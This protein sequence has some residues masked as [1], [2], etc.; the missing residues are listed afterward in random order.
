MT[1]EVALAAALPF[2][3]DKMLEHT[4]G[5]AGKDACTAV[6]RLI[7]RDFTATPGPPRNHEVARAVRRAELDALEDVVGAYHQAHTAQWER[8]AATAP[9]A[10]TKAANEFCRRHRR[11]LERGNADFVPSATLTATIEALLADAP[12]FTPAGERAAALAAFAEEA[13]LQELHDALPAAIA[14]PDDFAA[15]LRA[16]APRFLDQFGSYIGAALKDPEHGEFRAIL[17]T[18]WLAELKAQGFD[19]G[20]AVARLEQRLDQLPETIVT[21]LVAELEK[22]D[23]TRRA[24]QAGLERRTII[25]LARRLKPQEALDFDQALTELEHA[26]DIAC[27][28]IARGERPSNEDAFVRGVLARVADAMRLGDFDRGA[29]EVD[30]A[31]AELVRREADQRDEMRRWRTALLEA[32][33]EQDTLRR[34]AA[35]VAC[36]IEA[37]VA[38]DHPTD[39]AAW[40]PAFQE[41]WDALLEEGRDKGVNFSLQV[42]AA[43]ARRM[44][45]TARDSDERGTAGN[46][47]GIALWTLGQRESGTARLDQAVAAY[48]AALEEFARDRAAL[49]WARTQNNLG[50]AL[51][52]LGERE[53]GTTRLELAVAAYRAALEEFARDRAALDW[54]RTQNNLGN[55]LRTLGER[56]SGTARLELAVAAYRAALEERTRDRVPLDWA[57]TQMNLGNAL[58]TLGERESGTARLEQAVAAYRAALEEFTRD[59]VPL[60]WATTQ[61]NLG[62]ALKALGERESG[63]ARL[64]QAVAAYHATLEERTCDRVPLDWATT[65]MNLGNALATLG[66]R[67]SGTARLEQ[68]VAAWDACLAVTATVWPAEWVQYVRDCRDQARSEIKQRS[69]R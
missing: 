60:D 40:T 39:R 59:R 41:R 49:D 15:F 47:F 32:G 29:R 68:A 44:L 25:A 24:E 43:L 38:L 31:L 51:R 50:N 26:A 27:D 17:T 12:R 54:A 67:E 14:I 13:V 35:A 55:A 64:E 53:S 3:L 5:G 6:A 4:I 62:I 65:Q 22:R 18:V 48:C 56:E 11:L 46:L 16:G 23:T 45:K 20:E 19:A 61:N 52:T 69:A 30:Q 21:R 28:V 37:L 42:T 36:R 9:V 34:D 33:V 66:E 7:W 8:E 58:T 57:T 2:V 63:T 1:L 10:F